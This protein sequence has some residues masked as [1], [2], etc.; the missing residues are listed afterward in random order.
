MVLLVE[1]VFVLVVWVSV[2]CFLKDYLDIYKY[3]KCLIRSNGW[4][5]KQNQNKENILF[6]TY[7]IFIVWIVFQIERWLIVKFNS[8]W[9]FE[10]CNW[11]ECRN[12]F[13]HNLKSFA[14][15]LRLHLVTLTL[16]KSFNGFRSD[17]SCGK[18]R[19]CLEM[20]DKRKNNDKLRENQI[21]SLRFDYI[22]CDYNQRD[23]GQNCFIKRV[24]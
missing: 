3:L 20:D 23:E 7:L 8:K 15:E 9:C 10:N 22:F 24:Q 4:I 18:S 14:V 17:Y 13:I 19:S 2:F 16:K 6:L 5:V 11:L 1:E 21:Y 12:Y